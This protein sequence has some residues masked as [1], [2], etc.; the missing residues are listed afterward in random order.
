MPSGFPCAYFF[1][2]MPDTF[3]LRPLTILFL[4]GLLVCHIFSVGASLVGPVACLFS[5][6]SIQLPF[7][8]WVALQCT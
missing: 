6:I 1:G 7:V 8:A 2:I 4:A 3:T 5:F